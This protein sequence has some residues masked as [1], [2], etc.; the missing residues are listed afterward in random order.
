MNFSA[1]E[2]LFR[3]TLQIDDTGYPERSS[4]S[5]RHSRSTTEIAT[6][7]QTIDMREVHI[8]Q[9]RL[10]SF[11]FEHDMAI[12]Q[13]LEDHA[14]S[15]EKKYVMYVE[16]FTMI[17]SD[18]YIFYEQN[19]AKSW[20]RA[21]VD[22]AFRKLRA[23]YPAHSRTA[24]ASSSGDSRIKLEAIHSETLHCPSM[25]RHAETSHPVHQHHS[26]IPTCSS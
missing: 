13:I 18:L 24:S 23:R 5:V 7:K 21:V 20:R 10:E 17:V 8:N 15:E 11:S 12:I 14:T 1:L 4:K 16:F 9:I 3:L 19:R 25:R 2:W 22:E 6:L 26:S